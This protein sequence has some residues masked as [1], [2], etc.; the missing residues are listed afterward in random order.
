[1]ELFWVSTFYS[2]PFLSNLVPAGPPPQVFRFFIPTRVVYDTS[3]RTGMGIPAV[4]RR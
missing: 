2:P 4:G 1:M 3:T